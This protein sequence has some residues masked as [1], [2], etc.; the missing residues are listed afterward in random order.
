MGRLENRRCHAYRP[1]TC[2]ERVMCAE[3]KQVYVP[4]DKEDTKL[5]LKINR[6]MIEMEHK[7][8]PIEEASKALKREFKNAEYENHIDAW[9]R[10]TYAREQKNRERKQKG[11]DTFYLYKNN[12]DGE[13][14]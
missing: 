13:E 8:Y 4:S 11:N 12:G 3:C 7:G 1:G 6:R 10:H 9:L 5:R 14:R 2:I